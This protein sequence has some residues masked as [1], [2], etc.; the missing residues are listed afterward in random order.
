SF[1]RQLSRG[2]LVGGWRDRAGDAVNFAIG[3]GD[4]TL[5]P[6]QLATVYSTLA[7]G[8][9]LWSPR[10]GKELIAPNGKQTPIPSKSRGRGPVPAE[11]L[12]YI[13]N[14]LKRTPRTGTAAWKFIGFP[15]DK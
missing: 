1:L 9:T 14:A 13:D 5:T 2:F 12:H 3:Q 11:D 7:N 4:T 15:L 8:G 10:V 6:L